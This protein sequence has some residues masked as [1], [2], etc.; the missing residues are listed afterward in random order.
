MQTTELLILLPLLL[1]FLFG[2]LELSFIFA[3][4][5]RLKAASM[6]AC[7]VASLTEADARQAEQMQ[8][9]VEKVLDRPSLVSSYELELEN[10]KFTGD[11][12]T[13]EL[14]LPMSSAAPNLLGPLFSL[15]GRQLKAR[16]VMRKE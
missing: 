5:H 3:A 1:V 2:C 6:A 13:V 12:V 11:L 8:L 4:N 7:R 9:A 14:R 10:G 16:T 15:E